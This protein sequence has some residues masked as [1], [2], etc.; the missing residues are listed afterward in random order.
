ML[1]KTAPDRANRINAGVIVEAPILDRQYRLHHALRDHLQRNV[2]A[3]LA[4]RCDE[5]RDERSAQ[6]HLL[7]RRYLLVDD[8]DASDRRPRTRFRSTREHDPDRS[9]L[10]IAV[11][12]DEHQRVATDRE[13]AELFRPLPVRVADLVQALDQ[14]DLADGL[15]PPKL[16]RTGKHPRIHPL[17]LAVH[18]RVDHAREDHPVVAADAC[19]KEQRAGQPD[20]DVEPPAALRKTG[21]NP[22]PCG[23]LRRLGGGRGGHR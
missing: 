20:E 22:L 10:P 19:K 3:L 15:P 14:L 1:L 17:H 11:A 18:P 13:L 6:R 2:A 12:G 4:P 9:S 16:E 8:F 7:D 23:G 5:R 21:Q